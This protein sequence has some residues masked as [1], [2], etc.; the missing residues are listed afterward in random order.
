MSQPKRWWIGLIP[1]AFV[2]FLANQF[3]MPVVERD[4]LQRTTTAVSVATP[5]IVNPQLS[6]AGRDVTIGGSALQAEAP[7]LAG[8]SGEEP[9]D[10]QLKC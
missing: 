3:Q 10:K 8:Q 1:L 2:W 7:R 5:A 4:I 6:V 9:R